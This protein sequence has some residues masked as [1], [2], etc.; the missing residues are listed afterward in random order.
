MPRLPVIAPGRLGD[1]SKKPQ[2][3]KPTRGERCAGPQPGA[4]MQHTQTLSRTW[5]NFAR[6]PAWI[7]IGAPGADPDRRTH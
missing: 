4:A 3:A 6:L 1:N 5:C 2:Q 7:L